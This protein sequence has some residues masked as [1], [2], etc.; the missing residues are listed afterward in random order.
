MIH[1]SL[2]E[3]WYLLVYND[4]LYSAVQDTSRGNPQFPENVAD[5]ASDKMIILQKS[6]HVEQY[7]T[8]SLI[9]LACWICKKQELY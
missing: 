2:F 1:A 4:T 3:T 6:L 8:Y 5:L 9:S 7:V